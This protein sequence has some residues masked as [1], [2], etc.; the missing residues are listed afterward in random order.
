[1]QLVWMPRARRQRHAAIEYIAQDNQGAAL[2]VLDRIEHQTDML[3]DHPELGRPGRKQGTRELVISRT[4]FIAV[5]R[6]RPKA[7]RI[8]LLLLLHSSQQWPTAKALESLAD[9]VPNVEHGQ[10]MREAQALAGK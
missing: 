10:V 9:P 1:M 7:K 6:V 5:Y 8:E 4:P 3:L 2:D